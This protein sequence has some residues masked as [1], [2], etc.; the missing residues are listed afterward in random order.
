M[1]RRNVCNEYTEISPAKSI[2]F[3]IPLV[4]ETRSIPVHKEM[5]ENDNHLKYF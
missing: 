3:I 1:A 4:S 2:P 5:K